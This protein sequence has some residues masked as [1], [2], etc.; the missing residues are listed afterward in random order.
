MIIDDYLQ[1]ITSQYDNSPKFKAWVTLLLTPLVDLQEFANNLH[2]YFDIDTA[3]G[4]QLDM[5][6]EVIGIT[7]VL[8]FQPSREGVD[9]LLDDE[10][11]RFLLKSQI[12]RNH[13][14]GTNLSIYDMWTILHPEIALS[15]KDNQDMTV[16]ALFIGALDDTELEM[17]ENNMIVPKAQGVLMNYAFSLPPLFSHDQD[18]DYFKG[19]DEGY[20]ANLG[21]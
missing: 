11:Y 10:H 12:I 6:G 18:T 21:G 16:T 7:R 15:I 1:L 3:V 9:P 5:L 13:W 4:K 2:T 20:W 8:P 17:I 14:D 19:Y